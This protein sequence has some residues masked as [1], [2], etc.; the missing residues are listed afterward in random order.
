MLVKSLQW[1]ATHTPVEIVAKLNLSDQDEINSLLL[2]LRKYPHAFS[3]DG[4]FS[5]SQLKETEIFFQKSNAENPKAQN[6]H[7]ENIINDKWA[8]RLK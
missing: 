2:T 4:K 1:I 6:F 5:T 7:I 8:G 3:T